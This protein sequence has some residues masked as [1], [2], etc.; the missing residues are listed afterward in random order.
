MS[1]TI[2]KLAV[3]SSVIEQMPAKSMVVDSI[4]T[5]SVGFPIDLVTVNELSDRNLFFMT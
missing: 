2:F 4:P 3:G 5:K 1:S